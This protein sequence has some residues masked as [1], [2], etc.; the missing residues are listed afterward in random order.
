M[1]GGEERNSK[2]YKIAIP[3]EFLRAEDIFSWGILITQTQKC[4]RI[5]EK[6]RPFNLKKRQRED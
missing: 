6:R 2:S 5:K 1:T 3:I 4:H